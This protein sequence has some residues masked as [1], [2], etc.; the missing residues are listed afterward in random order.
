MM[1]EEAV[2]A[3]GEKFEEALHQAA[4]RAHWRHLV[5]AVSACI[6]YK[7]LVTCLRMPQNLEQVPRARAGDHLFGTLE[8]PSSLSRYDNF[9]DITF[10]IIK[11][12]LKDNQEKHS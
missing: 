3:S 4:D 10:Q 1:D 9:M 8:R 7:L 6:A 2:S 12:I 11:D 5:S